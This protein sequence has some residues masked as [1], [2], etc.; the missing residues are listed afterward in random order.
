MVILPLPQPLREVG[1][2]SHL[3]I[4]WLKSETF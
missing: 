2:L 4:L 3:D 1:V